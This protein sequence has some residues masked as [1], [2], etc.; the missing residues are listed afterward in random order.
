MPVIVFDLDD[1]LYDQMI[2]FKNAILHYLELGADKIYHI[3]L[4]SR[5]YSDQ[6]FAQSESKALS[7]DDMHIYRLKQALLD[8]GIRL[9]DT[10]VLEIQATYSHQQAQ[11]QL[12]DG[13]RHVLD[14]CKKSQIVL[15]L[16]TNGPY[17]HQMKKIK[18]LELN[19]WIPPRNIIIS[20]QF[21]IAK[22]ALPIFE[23]LEKII[24]NSKENYYYIGDSF[25]NDVI[26]AA[27]AGWKS[28][29]FNHRQREASN[30]IT[31]PNFEVRSSEELL[32]LIP[33]LK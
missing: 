10:K 7:M 23:A 21:G 19:R 15:G 11:I 12:T 26:G 28:I 20:G 18:R 13:M 6:V 32:E 16:I 30:T 3:Y 5:K 4:A 14:Y 27:K 24:G 1:T 8:Y 2:P 9:S 17:L 29:W 25:E 33:L 22:P 31:L